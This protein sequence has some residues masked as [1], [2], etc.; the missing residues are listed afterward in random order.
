MSNPNHDDKGRFSFGSGG[1]SSSKPPHGGGTHQKTGDHATDRALSLHQ[2]ATLE[3]TG[4]SGPRD[5]VA[6]YQR[7]IV[8]D[9]EVADIMRRAK[10][11][12]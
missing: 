4:K 6:A 7:S 12:R 5:S 10:F 2:Q 8:S 3:R 11:G 1:G 9:K